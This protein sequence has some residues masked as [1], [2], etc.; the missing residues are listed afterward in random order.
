MCKYRYK[1][2]KKIGRMKNNFISIFGIL[3]YHVLFK[4][5]DVS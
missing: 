3:S 1:W 2:Q 5:Y 4:N